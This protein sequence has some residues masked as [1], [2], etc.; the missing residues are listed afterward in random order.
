[1]IHY[2]LTIES[3]ASEIGPGQRNFPPGVKR[4]I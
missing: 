1:M 2:L 4:L 3:E